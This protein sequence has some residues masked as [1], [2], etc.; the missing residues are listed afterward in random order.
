MRWTSPVSGTAVPHDGQD[1]FI[2]EIV[3]LGPWWMAARTFI[4][5]AQATKPGV[6]GVRKP[7]GFRKPSVS[8]ISVPSR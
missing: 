8:R 7:L 6:P 4:R 1:V 3:S 5:W 2:G